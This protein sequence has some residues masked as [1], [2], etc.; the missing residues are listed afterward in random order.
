MRY[1][2]GEYEKCYCKRDQAGMATWARFSEHVPKLALLY[3]ISKNPY[4]PIVCHESAGW[5]FDI[6][7][8]IVT[9]MLYIVSNKMARTDFQSLTTSLLGLLENDTHTISRSKALK[10]LG[11][12]PTELVEVEQALVLQDSI[13]IEKKGLSTYYRLL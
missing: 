12:K 2:E 4:N 3:A 9:R 6:V 13:V 10:M 8:A 5:S 7:K 1:A 11:I